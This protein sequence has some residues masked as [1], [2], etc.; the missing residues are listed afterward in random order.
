MLENIKWLIHS[1]LFWVICL[2]IFSI[3]LFIRNKI[4]MDM[5]GLLMIVIFIISGIL[6]PDEA[7]AGFSDQNVLLIACLFVIGEGLVRTGVAYQVGDWL[8][9]IA[10]NSEV[11]MLI[12]LMLTVG[13]LGSVMSS[14][15]IVA[16]FIP[17]VLTV[18]NSMNISPGRLMMPLSFAG[19]ISGMT[20]LV[21]TPPN[22]VVNSEL[23]RYDLPQF[24]FFSIT[25]IGLTI[26]ALGI[27]YMLIVHHVV[28]KNPRPITKPFKSSKK[29]NMRDLVKEYQLHGRDRHFIILP[30][31]PLIGKTLDELGLR[32]QYGINIV[33]IERIKRFRKG[34]ISAVAHTQLQEND[35]LLVDVINA[36]IDLKIF[37][38]ENG[39]NALS[40]RGDYFYEKSL[41][42]GMAEIALL[43]ESQYLGKTVREI[44]FRT[45]FNLNVIGIKRQTALI[46][47]TQHD[48]L[49]E[50]LQIGDTLLVIGDWRQIRLL[51][52][53]TDN[54][55]VINLPAEVDKIVP[56]YSQAPHALFSLL[57]MVILMVLTDVPNVIA[58]MI[59]C[60][61]M[62]KFRC[63]N[64]ESAYRS[65]HWPSLL[66]I[67]GMLPFALALQKTGGV[68]LIVQ[69]LLHLAGDKGPYFMLFILF[70]LCATIGLFISNTATAVLMAPIAIASAQQM[71]LSVLPFA[72]II[73][74]S[75]S[76]A[77]M[78]PISSPVNTMVLSPGGYRF[79]DF[80]KVG[81]PFTLLVMVVSI[82]LIPIL[83]PF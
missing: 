78:T 12:F 7:L 52:L 17:I 23:A 29:R 30:N 76:S 39:L 15:G 8:V 1:Q 5:I 2:L 49:D 16:I 57:T 50:A 26:L 77:F 37:C 9:K 38:K 31:S 42:V 41:H 46:G 74:I 35:E 10:G 64:A 53:N 80:V 3:V 70:I 33:G 51:Q 44:E 43:P 20:T 36:N 68:D 13:G 34:M 19:L 28:K 61:L 6:K 72:M 11:K 67:V 83:F 22:L 62:A 18:C 45:K 25:P 4:R 48:E 75:A 40:V 21:A 69:G 66:L 47:H 79:M 73:A 59:G 71:N 82:I 54:F 24:S 63:I 81:V 27:I 14:T 56:A 55:Y 65:I 60:L 58:A 32:S